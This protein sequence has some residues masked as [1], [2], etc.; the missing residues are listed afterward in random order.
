MCVIE[1]KAGM[2]HTTVTQSV[3]H[4]IATLKGDMRWLR[5]WLHAHADDIAPDMLKAHLDRCDNMEGYLSAAALLAERC[6]LDAI[7]CKGGDCLD[8]LAPSHVES[9]APQQPD[10]DINLAHIAAMFAAD[11]AHT[12]AHTQA[13]MDGAPHS[14]IPFPADDPDA[15]PGWA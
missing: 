11:K 8:P 6:W 15:A 7:R 5:Q 10:P 14:H 1:I 2:M 4:N 3:A 12:D 9:T 13:H